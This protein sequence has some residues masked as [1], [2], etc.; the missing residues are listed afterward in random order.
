MKPG[1]ALIVG[2]VLILFVNGSYARLILANDGGTEIVV[3]DV[4][5]FEVQSLEDLS[6]EIRFFRDNGSSERIDKAKEHIAMRLVCYETENGDLV[7]EREYGRR[8]LYV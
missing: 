5:R 1:S 8:A 4:G 6:K 7:F 3:P 2:L